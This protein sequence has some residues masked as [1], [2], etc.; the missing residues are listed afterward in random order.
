[1]EFTRANYA[2]LFRTA[3]MLT[4]DAAGAEDL[5]QDTLARLYPTWSRVDAADNPL[6]YVRRSLTNLFLTS[7]RRAWTTE[8]V[9]AWVPDRAT[10]DASRE[11]VD[12]AFTMQLLAHLSDR[13][14]AAV[15]MRYLHDM[16][17]QEIAAS[18]GCRAVTARSLISRALSAMRTESDRIDGLEQGVAQGSTS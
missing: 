8:V 7:R 18:I 9:T 6:A 12:R 3:A 14:R 13:Q 1:V 17:D 2:S 16:T 4:G 11:V 5:V 15:V 10:A